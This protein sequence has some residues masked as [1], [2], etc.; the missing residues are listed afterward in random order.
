LSSARTQVPSD[1]NPSPTSGLPLLPSLCSVFSSGVHALFVTRFVFLCLLFLPAQLRSVRVIDNYFC[2]PISH[3]YIWEIYFINAA[4][5]P[6]LKHPVKVAETSYVLLPISRSLFLIYEYRQHYGILKFF[7]ILMLYI[8][9]FLFLIMF[10]Y[11]NFSYSILW[12]KINVSYTSVYFLQF[13]Y[14]FNPLFHIIKI[15]PREL[16]FW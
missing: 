15:K 12:Y 7:F 2:S 14:I 3:Y 16:I 5:Y 11:L 4:G 6:V 9:L 10:V 8:F 13:I 1:V